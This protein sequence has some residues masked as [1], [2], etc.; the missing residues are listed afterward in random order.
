MTRCTGIPQTITRNQDGTHD[1]MCGNPAKNKKADPYALPP[2]SSSTF[3]WQ[4]CYLLPLT[5][6]PSLLLPLFLANLMMGVVFCTFLPFSLS[7]SFLLLPLFLAS[8]TT[9]AVLC[10]CLPCSLL[11]LS[12]A[13]FSYYG[14][15]ISRCPSLVF[16]TSLR[17][18]FVSRVFVVFVCDLGLQLFCFF[19]FFFF[20]CK[21]DSWVREFFS[22]KLTTDQDLSRC[23]QRFG[24]GAHCCGSV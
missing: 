20:S 13:L 17:C 5:H 8:L 6:P 16:L 10:T 23:G 1:G 18:S 4:I 19:F 24:S 21:V 12:C 11:F 15:Y 3:S 22:L 14:R 2:I 9:G 7:L